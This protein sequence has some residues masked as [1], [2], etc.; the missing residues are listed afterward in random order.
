MIMTSIAEAPF[1]KVIRRAQ[2]RQTASWREHGGARGAFDADIRNAGLEP[3]VN[4]VRV[5][6]STAPKIVADLLK[7]DQV[8]VRVREMSASVPGDSTLWPMQLATSFIPLDLAPDDSPI[9]QTDTGV[10]GIYSRLEEAGHEIASFNEISELV[11]VTGAHAEFLGLPE[12]HLAIEI[13]RT[14][15]DAEG[16][17]VEVN[18]MML[19]PLRWIF[20]NHY[21]VSD[22]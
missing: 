17:N 21:M 19:H 10:G 9:A 1:K 11:P 15:T 13:F 20:E 5:R 6:P 2:P 4:L 16:R 3:V 12:G 18:V 14:A 8:R 7:T 22:G